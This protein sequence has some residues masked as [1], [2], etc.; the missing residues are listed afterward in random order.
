[1]NMQQDIYK[2]TYLN[3]DGI[4]QL[5]MCFCFRICE[6]DIG[7][8]LE[9]DE[10]EMNEDGG[11]WDNYEDGDNWNNNEDDDSETQNYEEDI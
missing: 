1:M 8:N 6:S 9:D 3:I 11:N 4:M 5:L 7:L 10:L 2:H